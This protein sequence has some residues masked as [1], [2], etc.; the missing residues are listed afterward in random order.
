MHEQAQLGAI[1]NDSSLPRHLVGS[2]PQHWQAQPARQ[3][4]RAWLAALGSP[5][6]PTHQQLPEQA[7]VLVPRVLVGH[8]RQAQAPA[9]GPQP[10]QRVQATP[11]RARAL[12]L[13]PPVRE[14]AGR[15]RAPSRGLRPAEQLTAQ[16]QARVQRALLPGQARAPPRPAALLRAP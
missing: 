16:M 4:W 8:S 12:E 10:L 11:R 13:Q 1:W 14:P 5:L 3:V 2:F 15:L 7:Q 6:A 9:R